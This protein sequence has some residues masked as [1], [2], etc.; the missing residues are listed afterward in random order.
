MEWQQIVANLINTVL[1]LLA[2]Q[3]IK[4][5]L[6]FLNKSVPWLLPIIAAAIGP[7]VAVIQSW[8]GSWLGINIDLSAIVAVFTGGSA[9]ALYQF[10][11][12]LSKGG[13]K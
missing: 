6:P 8:L 1:V 12:Q 5:V 13:Q 9:V 4:A 2:V 10:G 7:V 3:G 11:K